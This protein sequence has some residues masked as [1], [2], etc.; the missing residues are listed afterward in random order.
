M[1]YFIS[2]CLDLLHFLCFWDFSVLFG[3]TQVLGSPDL[4]LSV[5][6]EMRPST[7][8]AAWDGGMQNNSSFS[9]F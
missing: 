7:V 4:S 3:N 6:M 9:S 5:R 2:G 1:V 8:L